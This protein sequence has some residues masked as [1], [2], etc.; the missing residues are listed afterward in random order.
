MHVTG[1]QSIPN[2]GPSFYRAQEKR[3]VDSQL[4]HRT[5]PGACNTGRVGSFSTVFPK[6]MGE[7]GCST[8]TLL[9]PEGKPHSAGGR[10]NPAVLRA[11]VRTCCSWTKGTKKSLCPVGRGR[12]MSWAQTRVGV[13]QGHTQVPPRPATRCLPRSRLNQNRT[14]TTTRLTGTG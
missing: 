13:R 4:P 14:T 7:T 8:E 9:S 12:N 11:V 3:N 5:P 6:R 2:P 10:T 1:R